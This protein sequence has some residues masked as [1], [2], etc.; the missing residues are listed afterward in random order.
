MGPREAGDTLCEMQHLPLR[1]PWAT[2]GGRPTSALCC[3]QHGCPGGRQHG[4]ERGMEAR[5]AAASTGFPRP[6]GRTPKQLCR[7][8][9][10]WPT[11]LSGW[12]FLWFCTEGQQVGFH[13]RK[14]LHCLYKKDCRPWRN[15]TQGRGVWDA[16]WVV[17]ELRHSSLRLCHSFVSFA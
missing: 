17:F 5:W 12:L 2:G 1:G 11:P 16:L 9:G 10:S 6:V 8:L 13:L 3:V 4:V 14:E 15:F 7:W